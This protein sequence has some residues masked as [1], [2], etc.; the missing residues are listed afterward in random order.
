[1]PSSSDEAVEAYLAGLPDD[2]RT[3]IEAVRDVVLRNLPAGYVEAFNWGMI[4]YEVP[5][6]LSGKTYNGKPLMYAAIA[7]QKRHIG[8]H[9]CGIYV[10]PGARQALAATFAAAGKR[11]DMGQACLR[12]SKLDDLDLDAIAATIRSVRQ[13]RWW[14]HRTTRRARSVRRPCCRTDL[15]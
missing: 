15:F 6:A 2:R 10:Q 4:S 11:L 5:L 7:D 12:F 3:T 8:L 13:N 9:L 1:M 14:Q